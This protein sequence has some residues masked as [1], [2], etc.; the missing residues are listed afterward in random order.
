MKTRN[1]R[2]IHDALDRMPDMPTT[3]ASIDAWSVRFDATPDVWWPERGEVTTDSEPIEVWLRRAGFAYRHTVSVG[4]P[5]HVEALTDSLNFLLHA[6]QTLPPRGVLTRISLLLGL[7]AISG[8]IEGD[9]IPHH[10]RDLDQRHVGLL[11]G[12]ETIARLAMRASNAVESDIVWARGELG[13]ARMALGGKTQH[14]VTGARVTRLLSH[15][16]GNLWARQ[17]VAEWEHTVTQLEAIRDSDQAVG[18]AR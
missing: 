3:P 7:Q 10:I 12:I 11:T 4:L 14:G 9:L 13:R 6:L 1:I 2:E 8:E 17:L 5:G 15:P 16:T 18:R